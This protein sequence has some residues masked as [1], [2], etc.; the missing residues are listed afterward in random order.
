MCANTWSHEVNRISRKAERTS[1]QNARRELKKVRGPLI[2]IIREMQFCTHL[3]GKGSYFLP[4]NR[5]WHDGAANPPKPAGL[6]IDYLA[7]EVLPE[8]NPGLASLSPARRGAPPAARRRRPRGGP[9]I[10]HSAG[11]GKNN[12]IAWLAHQP[13]GLTRDDSPVFDFIIVVTDRRILDR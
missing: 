12:S 5:G 10:Q 8:P 9:A 6:A 13:I 3:T 11:S 7:R 4:F 2:Q 1:S